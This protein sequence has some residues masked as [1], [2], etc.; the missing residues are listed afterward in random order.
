MRYL[1]SLSIRT[2]LHLLVLAM[3]NLLMVSSATQMLDAL[4]QE[5]QARQIE[6]V[7]TASQQ[8]TNPKTFM[9]FQCKSRY[10]IR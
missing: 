9:C 6:A 10:G 7:A 4:R 2:L 8:R 1:K 5:R 3:G